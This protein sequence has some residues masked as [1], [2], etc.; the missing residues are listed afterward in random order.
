MLP[1]LLDDSL[2]KKEP[3]ENNTIS[4]PPP[5]QQQKKKKLELC[6]GHGGC[7]SHIDPYLD[8][9]PPCPLLKCLIAVIIAW[10]D[11]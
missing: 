2:P 7:K 5:E 4:P 11:R 8:P 1:L 9:Y 3:Q 6:L 10:Q